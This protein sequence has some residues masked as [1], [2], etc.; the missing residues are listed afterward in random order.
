[1][2]FLFATIRKDLEVGNSLQDPHF[3]SLSHLFNGAQSVQQLV[4]ALHHPEAKLLSVRFGKKSSCK[5]LQWTSKEGRC[6]VSRRY[7]SCFRFKQ[8][9]RIRENH[10]F[11][12]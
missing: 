6:I 1:M 8:A 11:L 5:F 3:R 4:R 12:S 2:M 7:F 9:H 10:L